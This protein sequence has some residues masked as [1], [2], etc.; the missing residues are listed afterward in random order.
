M[1]RRKLSKSIMIVFILVV[2][3]GVSVIA[4]VDR[5][6]EGQHIQNGDLVNELQIL[7]IG[8]SYTFSNELP[9]VFTRLAQ[10]GGHAVN[11]AMLAQ[12]G[13]TLEKHSQSAKTRET[14]QGQSWDYVILQEQS[15]RPAWPNTRDQN[16]YPAVRLLA[17]EIENTGGEGILFMTWGHRDGLPHSQDTD[18]HGMQ[19]VLA[20]SYLEIGR[21]LDL[22]IAPVGLAWQNALGQDPQMDLWSGD[23]SHPSK[24]GSYLAA[25]VF[26]A[27][28]FQESPEGLTYMAGLSKET[29]QFIQSIAAETVFADL[30]R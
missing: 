23:G 24:Q 14:I 22:I 29:G 2:L 13:W 25:C 15:T 21:E 11:V 6:Q 18:Y 10:E 16:M 28:I 9:Q 8:N 4:L 17:E 26:Y 12:G 1:D 27:V 30:E 5:T 7:F 3:L 19:A 20:E